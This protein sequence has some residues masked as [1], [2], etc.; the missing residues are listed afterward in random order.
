MKKILLF[1]LF[2]VIIMIG[3]TTTKYITLQG[4]HTIEYRD[5]IIHLKDTLTLYLEKER[6]KRI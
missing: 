2:F 6:I 5:S 3:C 1:Q 4:E